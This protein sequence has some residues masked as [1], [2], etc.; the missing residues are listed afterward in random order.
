MKHKINRFALVFLAALPMGA[1]A[2]DSAQAPSAANP[3]R[4]SAGEYIDDATIS[5][6]V[7]AAFVKDK[8]VKA[9][10]VKVETYKGNVQLSGFANTPAEIERAVQLAN[11]V[12]GV[13]SVR[14]DIRLK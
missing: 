1:I 12:A 8:D 2:A 3:S 6:K 4:E 7:R 13:K 5:T 9:M 14:N 11:G 10:D